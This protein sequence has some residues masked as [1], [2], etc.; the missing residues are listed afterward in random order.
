MQRKGILRNSM[1]KYAEELKDRFV[2]D[3]G[4]EQ[5]SSTKKLLVTCIDKVRGAMYAKVQDAFDLW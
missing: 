2:R 5:Y 1:F 3:S 4:A